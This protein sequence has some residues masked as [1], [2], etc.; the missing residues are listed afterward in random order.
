MNHPGLCN[1]RVAGPSLHQVCLPP[2]LTALWSAQLLRALS[3]W[4][5]LAHVGQLALLIALPLELW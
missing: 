1:D 4:P 3:L 2:E 5:G